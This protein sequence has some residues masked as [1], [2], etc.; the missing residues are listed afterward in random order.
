MLW[1]AEG[2]DKMK[3]KGAGGMKAISTSRERVD[4]P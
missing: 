2:T 1:A 4:R 3:R